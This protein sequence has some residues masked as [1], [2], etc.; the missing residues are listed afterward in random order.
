[1]E[2]YAQ[3]LTYAIPFF[4]A[5]IGIE[6]LFS[7][8]MSVK[9]NRGPDVISSLT[10]GI[11]NIVK[12]VLGLSIA[13]VSYAW[14]VDHIA[15]FDIGTQWYVFVIAFVAKDFAGYWIHR[16][17]HTVNVFWNRHIIH[18]SSEEYNLS[19]AL[20]QSV[21][22]IFSFVGFF[23]LPAA[24]IG[25]PVEVIA[26]IAPIQLFAQFWYHTRLI[27]KMGFLEYIIVT[28]SHHRVH[29]AI[30]AEYIYKNYGQI[31]II[32]DKLFGTFQPELKEVPPVYG[33]KRPVHT[34]NPLLI[35]VQH[36]WLILLDAIRTKNVKD[37]IKIW[38]MPTG[39]RP[40][41]VRQKYP[42]AALDDV[43]HFE[44]YDTH[45][46]S[47]L[48]AWSWI[49][50]A[51]LLAFTMDLFLRIGEI[52]FP[53]VLWYGLYLFVSIFSITSL[54]DKVRYAPIAEMLRFTLMMFLLY[55]QQWN[56][57]GISAVADALP[58]VVFGYALLSLFLSL[59]YHFAENRNY[60]LSS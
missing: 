35:G 52:G 34:W 14:L 60:Q 36:I 6:A 38:F 59:Y 24:L 51:L 33:V 22:E 9:I 20:R 45:V 15:L 31:F 32:W 44:K 7:W 40:D 4:L 26:I 8:R 37:K 23:L 5:L 39:W 29:H 21:S 16:M 19:C 43:Y 55:S 30:N 56:W 2:T 41:D 48:L 17:E 46:S 27:D 54:M 50:L 10:S 13:I 1:M 3:A 11:S 53:G 42:I 28:P 47:K 25:V 49:Q 18:H 58:F 12:D 57:F